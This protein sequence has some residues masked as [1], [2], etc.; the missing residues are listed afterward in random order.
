MPLC[1]VDLPLQ[2]Y[3]IPGMFKW[4]LSLSKVDSVPTNPEEGVCFT[5]HP[6]GTGV[7][8][9]P[10]GDTDRLGQKG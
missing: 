3:A 8:A 7:N 2:T 1:T 6:G 4:I 5:L 9:T 10:G